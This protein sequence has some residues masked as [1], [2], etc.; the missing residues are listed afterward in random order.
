MIGLVVNGRRKI[1]R[2]HDVENLKPSLFV[3][4]SRVYKTWCNVTVCSQCGQKAKYE[5]QH[6]IDPCM[7]CGSKVIQKVGYWKPKRDPWWLF[8]VDKG[9]WIIK[10]NGPDFFKNLE[11]REA[12][13]ELFKAV[14]FLT[15]RIYRW[16]SP[17]LNK[18]MWADNV[19]AFLNKFNI[20]NQDEK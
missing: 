1:E 9:E 10:Q 5:D 16:E 14:D 18:N 19:K 6:P 12:K 8:W 11:C 20:K 15:T 7:T 2:R 3:R 4:T 13:R 17:N